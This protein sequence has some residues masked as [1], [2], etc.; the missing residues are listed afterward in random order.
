MAEGLS[1]GS[2]WAVVLLVPLAVLLFLASALVERSGPIRLRHWAEGAGGA[3]RQLHGHRSRF[4]AFRFL[5]SLAAK[6]LPVGLFFGA[7]DLAGSLGLG[8]PALWAFGLVTLLFALT[9]L[10]VR[11][12]LLAGPEEFLERTTWLYRGLRI[13]LAPLLPLLSPL[14]R[15]RAEEREEDDSEEDEEATEGEIEAFLE[16][17]TREGILDEE[18][19]E[20]VW[21]VVDF[22]DTLVRSVMTPRIDMVCAPAEESLDSLANRFVESSHSRIPLFVDSID[23]IVGILHIRDVLSALRAPAPVEAVAI[24][25]PPL[26]VPETKPLGELL[27]ELQARRLQMAIVVDEYGGTAG[28]VTIEDLVEEIVGEIA[29][30]HDEEAPEQQA[31]PDGSQIFDGRTHI[32]KLEEEFDLRFDDPPFETVGGLVSSVLGYVPKVG[33]R[34]EVEGIRLT[35]ERSDERR[36]LSVR[37]ERLAAAGQDHG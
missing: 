21:G 19:R 36:V 7:A 35:V 6:L 5:L 8:R 1:I 17:G 4:E 10:A 26:F 9:E 20:L 3:L 15:R 2:L 18:E 28:L 33:D 23:R 31:L 22:G 37:V 30:E 32:E 11:S 25:Q 24:A 13:P 29:D 27:R 34:A 12:I 16:V 14:F